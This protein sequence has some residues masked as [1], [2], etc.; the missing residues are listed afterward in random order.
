MPAMPVTRQKFAKW[1]HEALNRL[2]DL[3]F[4]DAHPLAQILVPPGEPTKRGQELRAFLLQAVQALQPAP[5]VPPHSRDWRGYRLLDLRYISGLSAAEVMQQLALGRSQ[6]FLEQAHILEALVDNLW[7]E[8]AIKAENLSLAQLPTANHNPIDQEMERLLAQASTDNTWESVD[9]AV[10]V[11]ALRPLLEPLAR[12]QNVL[13]QV[14]FTHAITLCRADRVL[15]R[16]IILNL[17]SQAIEQAPCDQ[18]TLESFSDPQAAGLCIRLQTTGEAVP[19]TGLEMFRRCLEAMQGELNIIYSEDA[20]TSTGW[21]V[22]L[23]WPTSTAGLLMIIDDHPDVA[24]LFR[25]YLAG[26]GWEVV[27]FTNCADARQAISERRPT[28][29]VLDVILPK[30]DGWEFLLALKADEYTRAIPVIICSAIHEPRL[31]AALG[32]DAYLPKPV[33]QPALLQTLEPFAR[34]PA[35]LGPAH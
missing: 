26:S 7:R 21:Q 9:L 31:V 5:S 3:P 18:L 16:Q 33:N 10:L 15:L 2:Y 34:Q 14:E 17:C 29:I 32:A 24:E 28:A 35:S 20:A 12:M 25:R 27:S 6:F 19:L 22:R 11:H 13:L 1:V 30:E 23:A 8:Q 4:L